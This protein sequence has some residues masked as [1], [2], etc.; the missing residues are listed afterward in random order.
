[1]YHAVEL[2]ELDQDF[3]CF[4]WRTTPSEE[5]R[6]YR[7]TRVT[8]GVSASSFAANMAVKQNATDVAHKYPLA[9]EVVEESFY[10]DNCLTS[11]ESEKGVI[12]ITKTSFLQRLLYPPQVEFQQP[13]CTPTHRSRV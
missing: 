3:H 1:M 6:D 5:L 10:V 4:V 9:T 13:H 11:A 12:K 7:V 8:F 2:T